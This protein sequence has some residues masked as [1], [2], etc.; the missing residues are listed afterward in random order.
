[1][2]R[3]CQN[4][5]AMKMEEIRGRGASDLFLFSFDLYYYVFSG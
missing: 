2:L 5:E 3:Q 1:M 4:I